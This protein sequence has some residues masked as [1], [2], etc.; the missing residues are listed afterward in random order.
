ETAALCDHVDDLIR[1][2]IPSREV[3]SIIDNIG[4][5][6]S[7]LN[8]SYSTSAP[9]GTEDADILVSLNDGHHPTENYIHDIRLKLNEKFPGV[10]FYFAPADIVTQILNFGLPAPIDVQIVGSNLEGNRSFAANLL[11]KLRRVPGTAD[12]RIHQPFNQ[13]KL[14]LTVDRTRA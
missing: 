7:G 12:L 8:L 9:I 11:A 5:P 1:S 2:A 13:P 4:L 6:N 14:H 3:A 10:M